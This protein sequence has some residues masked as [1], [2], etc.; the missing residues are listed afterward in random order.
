MTETQYFYGITICSEYRN[1]AQCGMESTPGTFVGIFR[2]E[3]FLPAIRSRHFFIAQL[4]ETAVF[5]F[6]K[7]LFEYTVVAVGIHICMLPAVVQ[8]HPKARFAH[9]VPV[10]HSSEI[11]VSAG[12]QLVCRFLQQ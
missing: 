3:H 5:G 10:H 9:Q 12:I 11:P 8:A 6:Y 1:L 4:Q 2:Y 7:W